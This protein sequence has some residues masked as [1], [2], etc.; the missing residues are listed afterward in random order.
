MLFSKRERTLKRILIVE[1]E[2]LVAFD[3]EHFL[4]DAGYEIVATVDS[5]PE[6]VEAITGDV[7]LVLADVKLSDGGN[8]RDVARAAREKGVPLIFVTA[9]CPDDAKAFA[10]GLLSKPYSHRDLL[11]A[12]E[13][14]EAKLSGRVV[15]RLPKS[16]TLFGE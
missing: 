7:D 10:I 2:P 13:T 9:G 15:K 16:F 3:N 8:G 5:V 6:A 1:D 11:A 14:V 4:R 12:I